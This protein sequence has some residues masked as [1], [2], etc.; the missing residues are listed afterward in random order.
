MQANL[1]NK[2]YVNKNKKIKNK[3]Q[4]LNVP[5]LILSTLIVLFLG[6]FLSIKPPLALV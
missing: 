3:K 4:N 5:I 1:E 2:T 6:S